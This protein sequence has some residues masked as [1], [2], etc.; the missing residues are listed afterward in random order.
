MNRVRVFIVSANFGPAPATGRGRGLV[1]PGTFRLM[2][3]E[4]SA[5]PR[6]R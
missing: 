3:I 2:V 4:G 5:L 1:L 6:G